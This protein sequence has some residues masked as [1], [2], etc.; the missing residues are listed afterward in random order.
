MLDAFM[1][2]DERQQA[3]RDWLAC[4]VKIVELQA[5]LEKACEDRD[6]ALSDVLMHE[7]LLAD[8]TV[9]LTNLAGRTLAGGPATWVV[10]VCDAAR[11]LLNTIHDIT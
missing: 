3:D 5:E 1:T 7:E 4:Q 8:V 9:L 2:Y 10:E 11:E 6:A